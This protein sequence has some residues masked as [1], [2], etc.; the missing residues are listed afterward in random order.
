[1]ILRRSLALAALSLLAVAGCEKADPT[2]PDAT[3]SGAL[4]FSYTGDVAGAFTAE[5]QLDR[6]NVDEGTWAAGQ[7]GV[8]TNGDDLLAV[9][10][11][12]ERADGL[13]NQLY[14]TVVDPAVG[15]IECTPA[16][17]ECAFEAL[18]AVG[19][20]PDDEDAENLYLSASGTVRI[21]TLTSTRVTGEFVLN[22]L[23]AFPPVG[24][25][26]AAVQVT[27]GTFDV[28]LVQ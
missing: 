23:E 6:R 12:V 9:A 26:P 1:M 25:D 20:S 14:F 4:A 7:R 8:A 13:L 11:Q 16:T 27:A 21:T 28:P 2:R 10:A 3:P 15:T 17:E 5:G 22:L 24:A 18:F 19:Y